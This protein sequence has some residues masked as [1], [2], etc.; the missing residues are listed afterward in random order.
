MQ[1]GHSKVFLR[2]QVFEALEFLR[3][4]RLGKSAIIIQKHVRRF[5]SQLFYYDAI[6]AAVILQSF[7]RQIIATRTVMQL[8]QD[9]AATK[10]QTIF[11]KFLAETGFMA[12]KLIAHFCQSHRRGSIARQLFAIMRVEKQALVIQR[13]WR[14]Y[15]YQSGYRKKHIASIAIQCCWRQRQARS[16]VR[17]LRRKARDL[18]AIAAERDRFKE[19]ATKLKKEV[20]MLRRSR[21]HPSHF[22]IEEEVDSIRGNSVHWTS[23]HD[24]GTPSVHESEVEQLRMEV[25]RLQAALA[26]Q[27][28]ILNSV[29]GL[30]KPP[31]SVIVRKT[32]TWSL[33]GNRKDDAAS[34]ASSLG[35]TFSPQATIGQEQLR[36]AK[37]EWTY[38]SPNQK[39]DIRGEA[40]PLSWPS[41]GFNPG[42]SSS[43]VSLLDAERH[44][45][46]ADY[47]LQSTMNVGDVGTPIYAASTMPPAP[48]RI[49][50]DPFPLEERRGVEFTEEFRWLHQTIS[51]HDYR[52]VC[53]ILSSAAE[54]HV[55]VNEISE[56]G[57]TA[58]HIAVE[59]DD[60]DI[61]K[62][63]I[64]NGAIV[65]AQDPNGDTPLHLSKSP[66]M[67][68][69]LLDIGRANPNI[70]NIDGI[71]ALHLA[72]QRRDV[73]SV[74]I[75]LKHYAKV[76][77]AD[78]VRWLT[79]LHLATMP[80]TGDVVGGSGRAVITKLLC[81]VDD[82]DLNYQDSEGNTPLHYAVQMESGDAGAVINTLLEKGASPHIANSRNQEPLLLLCHN[83]SLRKE[84]IYQECLHSM[85]YHGANPNQ[86]SS[87]GATPLHLSLYHKDIDSAVQLVSR[88]AE[89]HL[90]WRK[91]NYSF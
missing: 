74:R 82:P 34:Q 9:R 27:S 28:Q 8:R 60:I 47:Q 80:D 59:S 25:Q 49:E 36:S 90:L 16:I 33:F 40:T 32:A 68:S 1:L 52:Q 7:T 53:K 81:S 14:R 37:L 2:R 12:V 51:D 73:V 62:L 6:M 50:D 30:D 45:E 31:E 21:A 66:A 24:V 55:L 42:M 26:K 11:R 17:A 75:L 38:D 54:S 29:G 65:N 5:I 64:D 56:H 13:S 84:D 63:L 79:P 35:N 20:D 3:N 46:I 67:T 39:L 10:I 18:D 89:L 22:A 78:N 43:S 83:L 77:A 85:L 71:C 70:P 48:P 58:L 23:H 72:V 15:N 88:A 57:R 44:T 19:E 61:T 76:D 69:F 91:V 41:N 4:K 86:Q 87:T